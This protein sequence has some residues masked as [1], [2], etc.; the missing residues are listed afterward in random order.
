MRAAIASA[1]TR[2]APGRAI[3]SAERHSIAQEL[4]IAE[5]VVESPS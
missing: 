1:A 3:G 2:H 4:G 5:T